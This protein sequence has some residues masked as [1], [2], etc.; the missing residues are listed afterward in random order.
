MVSGYADGVI[1]HFNLVD[2]DFYKF[3]ALWH[4]DSD[5]M[6]QFYIIPGT[7][8]TPEPGTLSLLGLGLLGMAATRLRK[9]AR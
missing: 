5:Q 2:G 7:V 1:S 8:S 6:E 3:E 4:N 9:T